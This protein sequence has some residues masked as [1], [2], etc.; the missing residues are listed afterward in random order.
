[1]RHTIFK[2]LIFSIVLSF[3]GFKAYQEYNI[4]QLREVY[5]SGDP[6]TWPKPT[7]DST[8]N[9]SDFK[10]IGSLPDVQFPTD[11]P[12][13]EAKK[14]L[15]KSLFFDPRLSSSGQISCASCHDSELGWGDGRRHSYGH[16]RREGRR[17]S[18]TILNSAYAETLFWDGRASSLEDQAQFPIQ[19]T[20]EMNFHI[21]L[22]S[23]DIAKIEGYKALFKA[24]FGD[25]TV[26]KERIQKA[27]ATYERTIVSGRTRFDRF[28]DGESK[29]FTDQQV[30]GMHLFRTKARCINC[31]NTGYFSDNKFHNTGL[32]YYGRPFEDLGRYEVTGNKDDV[33]KFKTSTL[34]EISRTGP[35]MH[36]GLFQNLYG[37][38]NLYSAGMPQP[39]RK[40]HQVNDTLF[41]TTS[42]LLKKLHLTKKEKYALVA[43][44][45][46]LE[47]VNHRETPPELPE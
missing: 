23:E 42:P 26:S 21:N 9:N 45:R 3:F 32:T 24:A 38:V 28:I 14:D 40:D 2:I 46:T 13:S 33:G 27:I 5:S 11:N 41:P 25:K 22:A 47:S 19:D 4:D 17:N 7:L 36:N 30:L 35:Y 34:R 10:D 12:Y 16:L 39:K 37:I 15:G 31:H 44:L 20:L 43:F 18:M 1:M 29:M 8:I 6:S